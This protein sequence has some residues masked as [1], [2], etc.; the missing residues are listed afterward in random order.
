MDGGGTITEYDTLGVDS[1]CAGA[2]GTSVWHTSDSNN[3]SRANI[4]VTV[5]LRVYRVFKDQA[6]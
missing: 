6:L 4:H 1:V 5:V 3:R 2:C